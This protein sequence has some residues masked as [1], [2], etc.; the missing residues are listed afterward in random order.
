MTMDTK[1][2]YYAVLGLTKAA[3]LDDIKRAFRE[4]A[5]ITHPDKEGGSEQSFL[6]VKEAYEVLSDEVTRSKYDTTYTPTMIVVYN[7]GSAMR[8]TH[9]ISCSC[10]RCLKYW[11][12]HRQEYTATRPFKDER[13]FME[14]LL[15]GNFEG[16]EASVKRT[17]RA[18]GI[19]HVE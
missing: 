12:T 8:H 9:H 5:L 19:I 10:E 4:M 6:E 7:V 14:E 1:K 18:H 11:S 15:D 2:D 16:I 3:T 17:Q 13:W